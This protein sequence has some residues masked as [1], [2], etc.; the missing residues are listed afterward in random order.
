MYEMDGCGS[1]DAGKVDE[2][3]EPQRDDGDYVGCTT[4]VNS[5][6]SKQHCAELHRFG[7]L[8]GFAG[9]IKK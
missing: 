7:R 3:A 4:P 8:Q 6:T 9:I 5:S 1:F 2:I